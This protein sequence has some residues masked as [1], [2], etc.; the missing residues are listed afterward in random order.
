MHMPL[1]WFCHERAHIIISV[2]I[3]IR[4]VGISSGDFVYLED[5]NLLLGKPRVLIGKYSYKLTDEP[6][7]DKTNKIT[8]RPAKTQISLGICPV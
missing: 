4:S 6:P 3:Y 2:Y 7:R 1:C 8:V 5:A